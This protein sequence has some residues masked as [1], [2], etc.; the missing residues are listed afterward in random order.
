MAEQVYLYPKEGQIVRD[1][2]D[3]NPLPVTGAWKPYIGPAGRY[4]RRRIKDG[5]AIVGNPPEPA[6]LR[7]GKH[8]KERKE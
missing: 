5:D 8:E 4:W 2:M 6:Q 7:G 1:P 3:K